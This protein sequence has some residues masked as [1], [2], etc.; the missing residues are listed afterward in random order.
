MKK[1]CDNTYEIYVY[2]NKVNFFIILKKLIKFNLDRFNLKSLLKA[3]RTNNDI[4]VPNA[5]IIG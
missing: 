4:D 5:N 3:R 2:K 1:R